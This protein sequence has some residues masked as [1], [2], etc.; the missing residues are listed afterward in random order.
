[1]SRKSN[2]GPLICHAL[3]YLTIILY[4]TR[5]HVRIY[6]SKF[7]IQKAC[8]FIHIGTG[9]M[10]SSRYHISKARLGNDDIIPTALD[11]LSCLI[12]TWSSVVLVKTLRRGDPL[13]TRP[14]YQTGAFVRP[15]ICIASYLFELPILHRVSI[16]AL[17]SFV[18]ARLAIFFFIYTPYLRGHSYSTIYSISIPLAAVFSIHQSGVRGASLAFVLL[19][20]YVAKLNEWVTHRSRI[21]QGTQARSYIDIVERYILTGLLCLGFAELDLLREVSKSEAL[22]KPIDDDYVSKTE[23]NSQS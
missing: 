21:L 15:L 1:M 23:Q 17:D 8:L 20:A 12:W 7:S 18:Y 22:T 14:P 5:R 13:T 9:I 4:H 19:T 6:S 2:M 16:S 3:V 10:E 11:V